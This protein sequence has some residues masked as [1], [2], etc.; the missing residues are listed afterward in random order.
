MACSIYRLKAH[1]FFLWGYLNSLFY[2]TP[3]KDVEDMRS[4][5]IAGCDTLKKY[6]VH[7]KEFGSL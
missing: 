6:L 2:S 7:V 1:G 5:I 3:V 4:R